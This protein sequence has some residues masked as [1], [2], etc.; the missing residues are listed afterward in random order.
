MIRFYSRYVRP[1]SLC[2]DLGAHVGNRVSCWRELGATVVAVEPQPRF[3]R[4][5]ERFIA[6]DHVTVVR[7]AVGRE[8]G[9]A[10]LYTDPRNPTVSTLSRQWQKQV[11]ADPRW[12]RV[13]WS[14]TDDVEVVTLDQ[15]ISQF[16]E[17][18]FCKIDVEGAELDVL[19]G[20]SRPLRGVS[21]EVIPA[22]RDAGL[23]AL[24]QL[25]TL[26]HYRFNFS[27][28]ESMELQFEEDVDSTA[29][30]HFLATLGS[31]ARSG[32]VYA[33]RL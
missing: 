1:G 10:C 27:T 2:F 6:D 15:L 3:A 14:R 29:L 11:K 31:G 19:L 25:E 12:M 17:P 13:E 9:R 30:R 24:A 7:S 22:A 5:L 20:A 18:A 28:S 32:D 4:Y 16:G 21:F 8:A 23:A 33:C 26:G